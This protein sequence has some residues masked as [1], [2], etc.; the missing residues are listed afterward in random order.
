MPGTASSEAAG[1]A[2]ALRERL[3]SGLRQI[4][5]F[6]IPSSAGF[7]ALGDV[8][9]AALFQTG[10]FTH[11]DA[12]YVW[13]ILAGST[14][15][16]LAS[17]LGRLYASSCYALRDTRTPLRFAAVR[18]SLSI[19]L[20]YTAAL[21]LPGLLSLDARWGTAGLTAASGIAGWVEF[22]LLRSAVRR[23]H[24]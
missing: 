4:A 3:D 22:L 19:V 20:G 5:F 24:I 18:L 1:I 23:V 21:V 9:A 11:D 16:L 7:L 12:V 13:A 10:R 15:G 2:P 6:V 8:I 17:T 14:V